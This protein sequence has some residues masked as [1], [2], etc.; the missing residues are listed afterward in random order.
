MSYMTFFNMLLVWCMI[1][2]SI[3]TIVCNFIT[4]AVAG[5][6]NRD[7]PTYVAQTIV[8]AIRSILIAQFFSF[9]TYFGTDNNLSRAVLYVMSI[10]F[11]A[12]YQ[13]FMFI[14]YRKES[15]FHSLLFPALGTLTLIIYIISIETGF[16]FLSRPVSWFVQFMSWL[17]SVPLIGNF[18][19]FVSTRTLGLLCSY[20]TY[21]FIKGLW[22][23][24]R[25]RKIIMEK[26]IYDT[27]T[28][29]T[30]S[31]NN[32]E[33]ASELE[34]KLL[35]T[36]TEL[37]Y[38]TTLLRQAE[39]NISNIEEQHAHLAKQ[40]AELKEQNEVVINQA[41]SLNNRVNVLSNSLAKY[42]AKE[43]QSQINL[44]RGLAYELQVGEHLG[45]DAVSVYYR[46]I[47]RGK[48]DNGIDL[49]I[50]TK[51]EVRLIQ[52][53]NH[54]VPWILHHKEASSFCVSVEEYKAPAHLRIRPMLVCTNNTSCD[55]EVDKLFRS[56]KIEI[57][58]IPFDESYLENIESR[59][60]AVK[61]MSR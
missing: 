1:F 45:K 18:I 37:E 36:Q 21:I 47:I 31:D 27:S 8:N 44:Q 16:R 28:P 34:A 60:A 22:E 5:I 25:D 51:N 2:S 35:S 48:K 50:T 54:S 40:Y 10:I 41:D 15:F 61:A 7:K 9:F 32:K 49:V 43:E 39:E 24:I 14:V 12:L 30:G 53:K 59:I 17:S 23:I 13:S 56:R 20:L 46:G 33:H 29:E 19:T 26:P 6:T 58:R 55:Y 3:L 4:F 57:V 42:Q 11:I 52:C 38:S